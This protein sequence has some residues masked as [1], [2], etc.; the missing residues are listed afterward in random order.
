VICFGLSEILSADSG[1]SFFVFPKE[2]EAIEKRW[3][4][5]VW[6][7]QLSL[8]AAGSDPE[9][10]LSVF[11]GAPRSD[12]E[13]EILFPGRFAIKPKCSEATPLWFA[14]LALEVPSHWCKVVLPRASGRIA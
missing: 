12:S 9:V 6:R 4:G 7:L 13:V 8:R 5:N 3:N 11:R 1:E 2:A 14:R 10:G